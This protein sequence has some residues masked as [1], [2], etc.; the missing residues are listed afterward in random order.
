[1]DL[2]STKECAR[3]IL[4]SQGI[5]KHVVISIE[6]SLGDSLTDQCSPIHVGRK[7]EKVS[8]TSDPAQPQDRV[9]RKHGKG[10]S[11]SSESDSGSGSIAFDKR[12]KRIFK[13]LGPGDPSSIVLG[14]YY[15]VNGF[16]VTDTLMSIRKDLFESNWVFE[17][18]SHLL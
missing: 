2:S 12:S 13:K 14:K 11:E 4:R 16:D 18:V 6:L 9:K 5:Y 3:F 8:V 1:M 17:E 7:L 10:G 15:R